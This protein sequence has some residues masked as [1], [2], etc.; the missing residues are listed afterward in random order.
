MRER[1]K[2]S[3]RKGTPTNESGKRDFR[4]LGRMEERE[5]PSP[6]K[7]TPTNESGKSDFHQL[8]GV[9]E[10]EKQSPRKD[11]P[12]KRRRKRDFHQLEGGSEL[13]LRKGTPTSK[14]KKGGREATTALQKDSILLLKMS[15]RV[16]WKAERKHRRRLKRNGHPA[17][18]SAKL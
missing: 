17:V 16:T 7:G 2:P 5:K 8:E 18:P 4:Q 3:P 6:R 9:D 10:R 15:H 12:N 11:T 14:M 1:E 13:S